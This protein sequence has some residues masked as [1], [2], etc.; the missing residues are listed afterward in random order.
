M[1]GHAGYNRL[2]ASE[3]VGR[4]IRLAYCWAHARRKLVEITRTGSVPI[5][6]EGVK[7]IG[8]L[9][10]IEV[11]CAVSIT[12][13]AIV[14]DHKQNQIEGLLPW[15]YPQDDTCLK[16]SCRPKLPS[17]TSRSELLC[18]APNCPTQ[19]LSQKSTTK[20]GDQQERKEQPR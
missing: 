7:R 15:N 18:E 10:R 17:E 6:E 13:T 20:H 5:A 1:D 4:D 9:Y 8:E 16:G 2:I 11:S 3:R 12:L 14:N 19:P